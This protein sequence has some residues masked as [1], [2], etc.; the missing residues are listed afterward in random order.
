LAVRGGAPSGG[1]LGRDFLTFLGQAAALGISPN[2][3][4]RADPLERELLMEATKHAHEYSEQRD[5]ALARLVVSE[6]ADALKRGH[7]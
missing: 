3:V 5:R 4:L 7:H 6:L 1:I 2:T